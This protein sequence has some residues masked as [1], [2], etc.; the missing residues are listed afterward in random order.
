MGTKRENSARFRST[1]IVGL[2]A[3]LTALVVVAVSG[4]ARGAVNLGTAQT[5]AVLANTT[6]TNTGSTTITGNVG[7]YPGTSVTGFDDVTLNG[8]LHV[9]DEVAQQ[10]LIDAGAAYGDL[11]GRKPCTDLTGKVLGETV[12]TAADPL[13]PGVY[14]FDDEAQLTGDLYLSGGG[15][16]IFQIGTTLTTAENS[17]VILQGGAEACN[18][19]WAVGSS[20]TLGTGTEFVGT[21]IA[22]TSITANTGAKITGRL[23]ALTGAVTLQGNTITRPTCATPP[24]STTTTSTTAAPTTTSTVGPTTTSTVG[25][26]TTTTVAPTT[27]TAVGPTTTTT[28]APTTTTAVGPAPTTTTTLVLATTTTTPDQGPATTTTLG[29]ATTTTTL[30]QGATT[31]STLQAG[32]TTTTVASGTTTTLGA[33]G[34][35]GA[36]NGGGGAGATTTGMLATATQTATVEPG[37]GTPALATTGSLLR[38]WQFWGGVA[39]ALGGVM[40]KMSERPGL[41]GVVIAGAG[42]S[43]ATSARE[44]RRPVRLTGVTPGRQR[45]GGH[46][47]PR[48]GSSAGN[49]GNTGPRPSARDTSPLSGAGSVPTGGTGTVAGTTTATAAAASLAAAT[50]AVRAA[51]AAATD[52]ST[53]GAGSATAPSS[54]APPARRGQD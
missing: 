4:P 51:L 41:A 40:I 22:N 7:L 52:E 13:P 43:A 9:N 19:F 50:A 32:T 36:G 20:A 28:V 24:T 54:T 23:F 48:P 8:T 29:P 11:Q 6:I 25:P 30:A 44:A 12:G 38:W 16:Y 14:C 49:T 33:G 39:I 45:S 47:G 46:G 37:T 2:L 1:R 53:T 5:F 10:A 17:R 21:I 42:S 31:T 18:I 15:E 35:G 34:G 3:V 27:T 26:T